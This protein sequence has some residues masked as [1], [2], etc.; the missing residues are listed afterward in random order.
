MARTDKAL[1]ILRG[2]DGAKSA[3][4]LSGI[5]AQRTGAF[6][7]WYPAVICPGTV[8]AHTSWDAVPPIASAIRVTRS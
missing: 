6:S 8:N 2:K 3:W 1:P 5:L 4:K 7:L